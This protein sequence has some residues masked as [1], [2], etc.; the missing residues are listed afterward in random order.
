MEVSKTDIKYTSHTDSRLPVTIW[1][2]GHSVM[3]LVHKGWAMNVQRAKS[4]MYLILNSTS[5]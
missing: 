1:P 3:A 4:T 5:V 2:F